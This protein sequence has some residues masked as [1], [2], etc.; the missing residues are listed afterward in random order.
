YSPLRQFGDTM[1]WTHGKHSISMGGEYRR[2]STTGFDNSTYT[3]ASPGNGGGALTA[4][5]LNANTVNF[6]HVLPC[7]LHTTRNNA[8]SL[9]YVL[10]GSINNPNTQYWIDGYNDL[11]NGTWQDATKATNTLPT[12]DPYGHQNRTQTSNE[13]SFF[14]KD[15]YKLG[16]RLTINLG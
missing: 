1:R 13:F 3:N 14:A 10:S 15:D 7:L 11:K 4:A 16:R 12:A 2:P 6:A 5:L 8:V 9:L